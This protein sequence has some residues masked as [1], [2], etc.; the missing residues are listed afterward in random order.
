MKVIYDKRTALLT[1]SPFPVTIFLFCT[2]I[3]RHSSYSCLKLTRKEGKQFALKATSPLQS[4]VKFPLRA[5]RK[6]WFL[7]E[8]KWKERETETERDSG[9]QETNKFHS[10][11]QS[12]IPGSF[13][14]ASSCQEHL[15]PLSG[16]LPILHVNI[17]KY[18]SPTPP[19]WTS[20]L[21]SSPIAFCCY[22]LEVSWSLIICIH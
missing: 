21:L 16:L 1:L 11:L 19:Y 5:L 10:N 18:L 12:I 22:F 6:M 4:P 17:Q 13:T 3:L 20:P 14:T 8:K 2:L 7:I 15:L 9:L